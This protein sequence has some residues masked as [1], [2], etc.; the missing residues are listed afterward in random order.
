MRRGTGPLATLSLAKETREGDS[1]QVQFIGFTSVQEAVKFYFFVVDNCYFPRFYY[2]NVN[3]FVFFASYHS[4]K[5]RFFTHKERASF[6]AVT[7]I[8]SCQV[9]S[10]EQSG[11]EVPLVQLTINKLH[12]CTIFVQREQTEIKTKFVSMTIV[13]G[14]AHSSLGE[15]LSPKPSAVSD[16]PDS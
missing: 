12:F 6:R 11:Q 8:S 9:A 15:I 16:C 7:K 3:F 5:L 2:H 1:Q 10:R 4:R 13:T 14:N